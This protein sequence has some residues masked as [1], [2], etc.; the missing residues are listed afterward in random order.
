[1]IALK[2]IVVMEGRF[3]KRVINNTF[4]V[5]LR[6][7]PSELNDEEALEL[8]KALGGP[9]PIKSVLRKLIA[10]IES[11]MILPATKA[12]YANLLAELDKTA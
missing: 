1:M 4:G 7:Q 9:C 3:C 11:Q 5:E 2:D 10:E 8:G 6:G 12:K